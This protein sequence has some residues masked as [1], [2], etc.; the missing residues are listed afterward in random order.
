MERRRDHGRDRGRFRGGGG[1]GRGGGGFDGNG[2]GTF[3]GGG[4]GSAASADA[5]FAASD[6]HQRALLAAFAA[7]RQLLPPSEAD[8]RE[9]RE[10]NRGYRSAVAA[11]RN[12]EK[13]DVGKSERAA[14]RRELNGLM[15]R[16]LEVSERVE[17]EKSEERAFPFE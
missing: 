5:E 7:H 15:R 16:Y 1:G 11:A 9:V 17:S 12:L 3:R 10:M 8:A 6:P 13:Q 4:H 2:G 14:A